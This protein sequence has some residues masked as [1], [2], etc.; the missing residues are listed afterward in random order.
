MKHNT[1]KLVLLRHGESLWNKEKRFTGWTDIGLSEGGINE[2]KQAARLLMNKGYVFDMAFCSVLTRAMDTLKIVLKEMD[3]N[4]IPI[5]YNWR[6]NERHYGALQGKYKPDVAKEVGQEQFQLWRRGYDT[7]PPKLSKANYNYVNMSLSDQGLDR[8]DF[9]LSESLKNVL[10]RVLPYWTKVVVPEIQSGK[11]LI[12]S[13]HGNSLRAL[14]KHLDKIPDD[15]I[16]ELNI[17]T[18][19]PLVYEFDQNMNVVKKC[20]LAS[21]EEVKKATNKVKS[22]DK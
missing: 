22:Q 17:P 7:K 1:C 16:S 6:L 8:S 21:D 2:A 20:Y 19:I 13:A 12:I 5:A 15:K 11:R 18:G 9:P 4:S 14:V 3:L 10:V